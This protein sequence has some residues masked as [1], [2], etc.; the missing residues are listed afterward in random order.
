MTKPYIIP[1][2]LGDATGDKSLSYFLRFVGEKE[3]WKRAA[4]YVGGAKKKIVVDTGPPDLDHALKYH[5]LSKQEPCRPDQK[6]EVQLAKAGVK[7]EEIDIA[8]LTH[9]H[10]DHVGQ[11]SKFPNAQFIVSEEELRFALNPLPPLYVAYEALHVGMKPMFLN[12]IER[13]KTVGMTPKEIVEGVSV[14]P[15]PGHTP[16]S[17]GVVVDT[18]KGP[19]VIAGDAVPQYGNLEGSPEE[20]LSY[21][22]SG[23]FTDMR[24]MWKS[25]ERIDEIVKGDLS[26]VI[27][28][29]DP[30]IFQKERYP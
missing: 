14:I 7:P 22:I 18:A 16:G 23:F 3:H 24:A 26:R 27:P 17:I 20:H 30:R 12:V 19:H 25:F 28:G 29:H 21:L 4:F 10:W 6:I 11:V 9:L 13:I 8:I 1:L 15:L 5:H 2:D